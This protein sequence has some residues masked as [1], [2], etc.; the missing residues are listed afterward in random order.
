MVSV[1]VKN[2][3]QFVFNED[4]C[5][6]EWF[7]GTGSGGQHRNKHQNCCRVI[8]TPSGLVETRQGRSRDSNRKQAMEALQ[9][10]LSNHHKTQ[11][12]DETN[13]IQR[14]QMGSGMRGDKIRTY[15]FQDNQVTDH[16]SNKT[17]D[18]KKV[19][20]GNFDLLW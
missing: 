14:E 11:F 9:N 10:R 19:M 16:N 13:I 5:V 12:H 15:R 7:S 1:I 3:T 4:D 6:I 17:A 8:H 20:K 18:L 2:E